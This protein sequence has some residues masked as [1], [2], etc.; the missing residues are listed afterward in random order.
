MFLF[1]TKRQQRSGSLHSDAP[2]SL[3][4][5]SGFDGALVDVCVVDA[6]AVSSKDVTI[7]AASSDV[8]GECLEEE[9]SICLLGWHTVK[10][11]CAELSMQSYLS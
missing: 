10:N 11:Q 8:S 7:S 5:N 4:L 6:D 1:A 2:P 9:C 3:P